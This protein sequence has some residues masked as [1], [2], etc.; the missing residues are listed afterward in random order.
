MTETS[1]AV[2]AAQQTRRRALIVPREHGAWGLLLVPLFTGVVAGFASEHRIWR[3]LLFTVAALSLFW[4]RTPVESLIGTGSLTANTDEERRTA[5][6]ASIL[7]AAVATTCSTALLWKGKDSWVAAAGRSYRICASGP[8]SPP[9]P[10]SR[11]ANGGSDG[12]RNWPHLHCTGGLLHRH[13]KAKRA[14]FHFM[15]GQ[16]DLRRQPDSFR[17]TANSFRPRLE[18]RSEICAGE[19]LLPG[20]AS[21]FRV[22]GYHIVLACGSSLGD[23]RFCSRTHSRNVV[24]LSKTGIPGRRRLGESAKRHYRTNK[25]VGFQQR[26]LNGHSR[27]R[28]GSGWRFEQTTSPPRPT[29]PKRNACKHYSGFLEGADWTTSGAAIFRITRYSALP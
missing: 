22:L 4:L 9:K 15:G 1:D 13:W 25:K 8:V 23:R 5:L 2:R 19:D 28:Q 24:V 20:A 6:V 18:F 12:R 27:K 17:S 11:L 26:R 14:R 3:L 7:L 16:L 29:R 21:I 10:R